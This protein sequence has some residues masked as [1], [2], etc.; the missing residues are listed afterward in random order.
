MSQLQYMFR[1]LP[2]VTKNLIIINVVV[3]LAG[4]IGGH[5]FEDTLVRFCGLH[6]FSASDFNAAQIVTYMFLHGGFFHLFFNMF[7]LFMFGGLLERSLGSSRYLFYYVTC[8][9]GAALV[10][11]GVWALTWED[12]WA[13]EFAAQMNVA[14]D[15]VRTEIND[16]IAQGQDLPFLNYMITVG[17]S[18]AI[19]GVLLAFGM[20]YPNLPTYIMFIPVPVK[21]KWMVLG[22]GVIELWLA[23][24]QPGSTIAH[25]A[26]LGGMLFGVLLILYWKHRGEIHRFY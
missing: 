3:W 9:I 4:F 2:P 7:T 19:F 11:E 14:P 10:Q 5:G 24:S 20:L 12:T 16:L 21:A 18:G 13:R 22:Y 26:H 6:Y 8:G 1:N 17:A 25:F 23:L 15:V